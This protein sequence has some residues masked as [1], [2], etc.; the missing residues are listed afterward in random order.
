M[1]DGASESPGA[2]PAHSQ[3]GESASSERQLPHASS[4]QGA[5]R[6]LS[7]PSRSMA[8][9]V[10]NSVG[11]LVAV[12]AIIYFTYFFM[13]YFSRKPSAPAPV[14]ENVRTV[15]RKTEALRIEERRVLTTYGVVNPAL[16]TVRIPIARAMEL[17]AA[18][19]ARTPVAAA[20]P[21][22]A[23]PAPTP[24]AAAP[25]AAST[26]PDS[27]AAGAKPAATVA[28]VAPPAPPSAPPGLPPEVLYR[29]V[30]M[31]CHDVDGRGGVVRKAM[32]VIP[33][34]ADPRWQRTRTDADLLHSVLEGKGK[35]MLP[36]KDKF[37]L[38]RTDP[39]AMVAFVRR[40]QLGAAAAAPGTPAPTGTATTA[41][42]PTGTATT[43]AKPTS[44]AAAATLPTAPNN[45]AAA[46][47]LSTPI[48]PDVLALLAPAAAPPS[49]P[50]GASP[51][52]AA[53]LRASADL[54]RVNCAVCHGPDGRGSL[55]RAA[56]PVIPDFTARAWQTSHDGTQLSVSVLEGKGT[57]M[58][59]WRGKISPAQARDLV[60]Y[61]RHFGPADLL[62]SGVSTSEFEAR[63]RNL[64]KQWD[65][66]DQQ[67]RLLS[68]P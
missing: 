25:A 7:P 57:L 38:A 16:K 52:E 42:A 48:S 56:M 46:L 12:G 51:E 11:N 59:P 4:D 34:F 1:T 61:I 58:P 20:A 6:P 27:V 18:E 64:R 37:A 17:I 5:A 23:N 43:A 40:F 65:D 24:L 47:A 53:K 35:L 8:E 36:M 13:V 54:F 9:I 39:K 29:A 60:A 15:V 63:Y 28:V 33:D 45:S 62:G 44:L 10:L 41:T 66:L 68:G 32:P 30:C 26:T 67:L 21:T 55:V 22:A 3:P 19:S 31:A 49:S 14:P 50:P 2:T